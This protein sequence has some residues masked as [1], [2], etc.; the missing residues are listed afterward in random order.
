[1]IVSS[2]RDGMIGPS[3]RDVMIESSIRDGMIESSIR[4]GKA[5]KGQERRKENT[6]HLIHSC[7][8]FRFAYRTC[9]YA[10][11]FG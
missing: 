5:N 6:K 9:L 2:I 10:T 11:G 7:A 8:V 4:D 3:I 1:M